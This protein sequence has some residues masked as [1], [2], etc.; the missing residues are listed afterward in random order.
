MGKVGNYISKDL[1][2]MHLKQEN[3]FHLDDIEKQM[4]KFVALNVKLL[5]PKVLSRMEKEGVNL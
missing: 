1:D 2:L 4:M 3:D 5:E